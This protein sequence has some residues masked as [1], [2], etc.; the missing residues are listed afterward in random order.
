MTSDTEFRF[1]EEDDEFMYFEVTDKHV[2]IG[3]V[4]IP[5]VRSLREPILVSTKEGKLGEGN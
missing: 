4:Y 5:K 1:L 2:F 3:T